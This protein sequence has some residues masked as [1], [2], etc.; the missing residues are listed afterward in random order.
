MKEKI[1]Q[2]FSVARD[3]PP[4]SGCTVS[5]AILQGKNPLIYFS[6]AKNTDI[7]AEVFPYHKL[8]LVNGGELEV[9]GFK[10]SSACPNHEDKYKRRAE[11]DISSPTANKS[12]QEDQQLNYENPNSTSTGQK[13]LR[14]GES[15]LTPTNVPV[16]FRSKSSAVYTELEIRRSDI[17]NEAVHPGEIFVLKDILPYQEG[18]IV[19]M[20]I[21]HNDKMK[22]VMMSFDEGQGL[23]EHS[24]PGEALIFALDGKGIIGYE[25][26]EHAI[27]AGECFHFAKNG[28]HWVKADG[29]F[30]MALLLTL[31]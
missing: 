16:G 27:K 30:K 25:G 12:G 8:I 24:A 26:E 28:R 6:L 31:E 14:K 29:K 1:G 2:S 10:D 9:Y 23:S 11:S 4:V 22:F 17:M 21:A 5:R 19:N 18:R 15:I 3:N 20:D 13:L 7:S